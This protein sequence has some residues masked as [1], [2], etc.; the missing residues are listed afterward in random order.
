MAKGKRSNGTGLAVASTVAA[1]LAPAVA[2]RAR[3]AVDRLLVA[4]F[5]TLA[6]TS[7]SLYRSHLRTFAA[8][9]GGRLGRPVEVPEAVLHLL[10]RG[11]GPAHELVTAYVAHLR[12]PTEGKPTGRCGASS[13]NGHLAALARV[14]TAARRLDVRDSRGEP[15]EWVLEVERGKPEAYRDTRGPGRGV[16]EAMLRLAA[17]RGDA[18]G[19]RDVAMLRLL[20]DVGL[21]R[22][23]VAGL[24]VEH[25]ELAARR[26]RVL[27]KGRTERE[28]VTLPGPTADA[29][30]A[31][32]EVRGAAPG[33]AFPSFDAV[34]EGMSGRMSGTAVYLVVRGYG[35]GAGLRVT[36]H[37]LR[38]AAVTDALDAGENV[39]DVQ[40]F[41]R[42][43]DVRVTQRY[44]DNRRDLG[45]GVAERLAA[46]VAV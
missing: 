39:R 32:L 18:K 17:G 25:L 9:V 8:F 23:E 20:Y 10:G 36:P 12:Q 29:L 46:R 45:G 28:P 41:A 1:P 40:R 22:R 4:A 14:V 44:D 6:P 11:R 38:H 27:G 16:V 31:W 43:R 42:H 33:P 7:A 37:G 3:E 30:A 15:V 26:V 5:S 24:D 34:R 35:A 21:R 19:K 2:S 13:V